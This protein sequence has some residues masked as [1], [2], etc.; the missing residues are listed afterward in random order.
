[1]VLAGA[2]ILLLS[3][4]PAIKI[5]RNLKGLVRRKWMIIIYLMGLF[6]VGFISFDIILIINYQ[7]PIELVTGCVFLGGAVFV[8]IIMNVSPRQ[9]HHNP[10]G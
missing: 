8:F 2:V 10:K 6:V 5:S 7:F 9:Y 1:M 4:P 3:F